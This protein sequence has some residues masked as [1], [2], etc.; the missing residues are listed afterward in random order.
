[1][2]KS[3]NQETFQQLSFSSTMET[4]FQFEHDPQ[5]IEEVRVNLQPYTE[6]SYTISPLDSDEEIEDDQFRA[7]VQALEELKETVLKIF[8]DPIIS[9][10]TKMFSSSSSSV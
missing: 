4:N 7:A 8:W 3:K 10:F 1:M 6:Y 2:K 5:V 9:L